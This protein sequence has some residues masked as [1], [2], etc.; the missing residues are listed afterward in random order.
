MVK[1]TLVSLLLCLAFPLI[2]CGQQTSQKPFVLPVD[3]APLAIL[4]PSPLPTASLGVSYTVTLTALG[5]TPP[6]TWSMFSGALPPGLTL[7][8]V[9]GT[10]AGTPT[11]VGQF[12]FEVLVVDS[13]P[14]SLIM[15]LKFGPPEARES[16]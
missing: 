15:I 16:E 3:P 12:S 7:G 1:Q 2:A 13:S 5:G 11:L 14:T 10:I 6:Y 4:T 9:T 8:G